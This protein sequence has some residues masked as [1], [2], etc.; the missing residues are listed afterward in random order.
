M[1]IRIEHDTHGGYR[2]CLGYRTTVQLSYDEA[3]ILLTTLS[4]ALTAPKPRAVTPA[5]WGR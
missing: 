2:L 1:P 5:K 4:R 3:R